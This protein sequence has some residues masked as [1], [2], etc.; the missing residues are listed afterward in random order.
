MSDTKD[1][2]RSRG[3]D[4]QQ[5][6]G[7]GGAGN[8]V[9]DLSNSRERARDGPD[10]F[11]PTRGREPIS[12]RDPTEIISTGRGGAGNIRS[13]SREP[14]GSRFRENLENERLVHN[15]DVLHETGV[16]S[17]GR[18]GLGNISKASPSPGR[19]GDAAH[20]PVASTGRGG[21]GNIIHTQ[22]DLQDVDDAER[23]AHLHATGIHSTGRGGTANLTSTPPPGPEHAHFAAGVDDTHPHSSGRGG[24]GNISRSGSRAASRD[25]AHK[26]VSLSPSSVNWCVCDSDAGSFAL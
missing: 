22:A 5:S 17:S 26:C 11:S 20:E 21:A 6:T 19:S 3:R 10:D 15:I 8:I 14:S 7:R 2:S 1:R 16:H 4:L 24:S 12:F 13:P 9:H 18:G 25:P 23:A